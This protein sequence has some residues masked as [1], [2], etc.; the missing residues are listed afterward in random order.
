[1]IK[2]WLIIGVAVATG[3]YLIY[4]LLSFFGETQ[5][6]YGEASTEFDTITPPGMI[7]V[8][9]DTFRQGSNHTKALPEERPAHWVA[10]DGF[11][12]MAHEVT[13]EQFLA[14]VEAT[15][16]KTEAGQDLRDR[17]AL[18]FL[19]KMIPSTAAKWLPAGAISLPEPWMNDSLFALP[20]WTARWTPGASWQNP[21]GAEWPQSVWLRMPAVNISW[22]DAVAY[23]AWAGFRLP[24]E[25]EWERAALFG[26][27]SADRFNSTENMAFNPD[28]V[29]SIR[30]ALQ[31]RGYGPAQPAAGRQGLTQMSGSVAE[32]CSDIFEAGHYAALDTHSVISNPHG[33]VPLPDSLQPSTP[34][35]VVK[36]GSYF[37][38]HDFRPSGRRGLH[39][40]LGYADVGFRPVVTR[41]MWLTRLKLQQ[42]G[43]K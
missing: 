28:S 7:W 39:P 25:A 21:F 18:R 6:V 16:Y 42:L 5:S 11:W 17:D 40:G 38:P 8:P 24:S 32:W 22:N 20:R 43:M 4:S 34:L 37:R 36:G 15:G 2:R 12:M 10:V 26:V 29:G 31:R 33:P 9:A 27:D 14:F 23:C 3:V 41:A 19:K 13:N 35:R 1:M 30:E